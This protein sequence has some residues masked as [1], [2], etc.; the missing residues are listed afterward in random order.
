MQKIPPPGADM[1]KYRIPGNQHYSNLKE[2]FGTIFQRIEEQ[3]GLRSDS[4]WRVGRKI[5]QQTKVF[6][7]ALEVK[8]S[9]MDAESIDQ[10]IQIRISD[11]LEVLD[12][13]LNKIESKLGI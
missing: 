11:Q 4:E 10:M 7:K 13:R 2:L 12:Q 9:I 8:E 6:D 1:V 3:K 5:E